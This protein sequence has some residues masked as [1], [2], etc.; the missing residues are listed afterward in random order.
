MVAGFVMMRALA[1]G[2]AA[3]AADQ[4]H[5]AGREVIGH[6]KEAVD[7]LVH[8]PS[9]HACGIMGLG[10]VLALDR[11][12]VHSVA[13][14]QYEVGLAIDLISDPLE[15]LYAA[16]AQPALEHHFAEVARPAQ[17]AAGNWEDIA[18]TGIPF[19]AHGL[20][21]DFKVRCN[22]NGNPPIAMQGMKWHGRQAYCFYYAVN[23]RINN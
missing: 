10:R 21:E 7:G 2:F 20:G 23:Y 16:M 6:E 1:E 9:G 15:A 12:D 17:V 18:E 3:D 14:R 8:V 19:F 11:F 13:A 22:R 4:P 5:T